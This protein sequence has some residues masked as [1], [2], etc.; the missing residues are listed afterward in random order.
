M[1]TCGPA[2]FRQ[3]KS[4]VCRRLACQGRGTCTGGPTS[5]M[6][7]KETPELLFHLLVFRAL[8]RNDYSMASDTCVQ[9]LQK[10]YMAGLSKTIVNEKRESQLWRFSVKCKAVR[11]DEPWTWMYKD[12]N[13]NFLHSKCL[14][15]VQLKWV[16]NTDFQSPQTPCHSESCPHVQTKTRLYRLKWFSLECCKTKTMQSNHSSQSQRTQTIQWSN[17]NSK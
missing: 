3:V 9:S 2:S 10:K 14:L 16:H 1:S 8:L 13:K 11:V 7:S 12:Q 17:Q 5:F 15:V 6:A 4:T